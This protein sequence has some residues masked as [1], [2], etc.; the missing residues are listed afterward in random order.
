[1][2]LACVL[3]PVCPPH[4]NSHSRP[5]RAGLAEEVPTG[6]ATATAA[7]PE[8]DFTATLLRAA[9]LETVLFIIFAGRVG[10]LS[11]YGCKLP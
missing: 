8:T 11:G 2:L 6:E 9:G 7:L 1:M 10:L 4:R 3:C 5:V